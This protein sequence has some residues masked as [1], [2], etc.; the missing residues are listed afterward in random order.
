LT[1]AKIIFDALSY[2]KQKQN[3]AN[4]FTSVIVG[5]F[6]NEVLPD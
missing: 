6:E 2:L 3:T 4:V 1:L 5:K